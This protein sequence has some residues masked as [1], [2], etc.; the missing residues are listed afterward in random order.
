MRDGWRE[1]KR[2]GGGVRGRQPMRSSASQERE[3]EREI[4]KE[5]ERERERE[6]KGGGEAVAVALSQT[7]SK[8]GR[9]HV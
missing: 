1:G 5:R 9:A 4:E 6:S 2:R 8:I 7:I 3:R